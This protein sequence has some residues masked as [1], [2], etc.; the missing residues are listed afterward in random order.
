MLTTKMRKYTKMRKHC[1]RCNNNDLNQGCF[2]GLLNWTKDGIFVT[3]NIWGT[4][5]LKILVRTKLSQMKIFVG[6][7]ER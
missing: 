6:T 1:I 7:I 3:I 2:V 5:K 4:N